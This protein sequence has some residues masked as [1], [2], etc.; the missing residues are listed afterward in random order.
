MATTGDILIEPRE[1]DA[2]RSHPYGRLLFRERVVFG[3]YLLSLVVVWLPFKAP[4]YVLPIAVTLGYVFLLNSGKAL[5]RLGLLL[6]I[7]CGVAAGWTLV[8]PGFYVRGAI[9]AFATYGGLVFLM[10]VGGG[11]RC[12]PQ[13][14]QKMARWSAYFVLF[15]GVI[16]IAEALYGFTLSHSLDLNNGDWVKGTIG[17]GIHGLTQGVDFSNAMFATNMA[18]GLLMACLV[19]HKPRLRAAALVVGGVS[20]VLASVMH[21]ILFF[22]ASIVLAVIVLQLWRMTVQKRVIAI[23]AGVALLAAL[24]GAVLSTNFGLIGGYA[25][26][27]VK[28]RSPKGVVVKRVFG[29]M[30]GEMPYMAFV[31]IGPG[32]FTSIG[33]LIATGQYFGSP[34]NPRAIPFL[35]THLTKAQSKYFYDQWVRQAKNRRYFGSTQAPYFSILS[36]FTEF[37]AF[38]LFAVIMA[39]LWPIRYAKHCF[40]ARSSPFIFPIALTA[41]CFLLLLLGF[42]VDYWGIP[43]ASFLGFFDLALLSGY[44]TT[45]GNWTAAYQPQER[46]EVLPTERE[47]ARGPIS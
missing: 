8:D 20:L 47:I 13:F 25:E 18:F 28:L 14:I 12:R 16:G 9:V 6:L 26:H 29:E 3:L 40:S 38:G 21:V 34:L 17:L 37:G 23:L 31:G 11:M 27:F 24:A 33:A 45:R 35:P 1:T 7:Y 32:Q 15:E 4:P 42:Q 5:R 46:E 2:G 36:V 44:C 43:Q 30:I 19:C 10:T 22:I 39:L 41:F